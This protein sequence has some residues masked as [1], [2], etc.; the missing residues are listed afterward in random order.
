MMVSLYLQFGPYHFQALK[1]IIEVILSLDYLWEWFWVLSHIL[2]ILF[3]DMPSIHR[4]V[5]TARSI[6]C[7]SQL[8]LNKI[9]KGFFKVALLKEIGQTGKLTFRA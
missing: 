9:L 2:C 8:Q 7:L 3:G 1:G 6:Y 4:V 5:Y